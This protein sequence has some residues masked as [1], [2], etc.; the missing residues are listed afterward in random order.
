MMFILL[1]RVFIMSRAPQA[2]S[3][4]TNS[5]ISSFIELPSTVLTNVDKNFSPSAPKLIAIE[6][7]NSSEIFTKNIEE[8]IFHENSHTELKKTVSSISSCSI[9]VPVKVVDAIDLLKESALS[10]DALAQNKLGLCYLHGSSVDKNY[11]TAMS[12]FLKAAKRGSK[13]AQERLVIAYKEGQGIKKNLILATYWLLKSCIND[14]GRCVTL[15]FHRDLIRFIAP[16]LEKF[17]EFQSVRKIEFH[18]LG[19][20]GEGIAAIA[21]LI[22]LNPH[23]EILDLTGNDIGG[24]E[25]LLLMQALDDNTH[26]RQLI[27]N[28]AAIDTTIVSRIDALLSLKCAKI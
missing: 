26:L 17:S 10:G 6:V 25:V 27:F 12:W 21:Q 3:H 18:R 4:N 15:N 9:T 16:V 1:C 8:L 20:I 2:T 13:A 28:S 19:L 24:A 23:L 5:M 14:E 7:T 22:Q 11:V